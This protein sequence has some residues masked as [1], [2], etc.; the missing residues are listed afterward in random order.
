[1]NN[2]RNLPKVIELTEKLC[3]MI[4]FKVNDQPE[5]TSQLSGLLT[6]SQRTLQVA[7]SVSLQLAPQHVASL[8]ALQGRQKKL[9]NRLMRI[10][11]WHEQ[12]KAI[13]VLGYFLR[14]VGKRKREQLTSQVS[15]IRQTIRVKETASYQKLETLGELLLEL[16][17]GRELKRGWSDHPKL[18][19]RELETICYQLYQEWH[20][21]KRLSYLDRTEHRSW[22]YSLVKEERRLR[23]AGWQGAGI[24]RYIR[25]LYQEGQCLENHQSFLKLQQH[26]RQES[27]LVGSTLYLSMFERTAE[28]TPTQLQKK[29][30]LPIDQLGGFIDEQGMLQLSGSY[31]LS[32][33][34]APDSQFLE[35]Y[36]ETVKRAYP[37]GLLPASY[38]FEPNSPGYQTIK[39]IHQFRMY[40]DR[41]NIYYIRANYSGATDYDKLLA[42][43]KARMTV[44]GEKGQLDY[45]SN[46]HF[47]NRTSRRLPFHGQH[48]DKIKSHNGLSEFIVRRQD[49]A[50]VTQWDS[51]RTVGG[52]SFFIK[53]AGR[54]IGLRSQL[55]N[56]DPEAYELQG[57]SGKRIV[58]T[59]S[60]NYSARDVAK[61]GD[62]SHSLLDVK[63]ANA[64]LGLEHGI[65]IV[66]KKTWR[67]QRATSDGQG[68][69]SP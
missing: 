48:N 23:V 16:C 34:L 2:Q 54:V 30:Q 56:S 37:Q 53:E 69:E 8:K 47:H 15:Q 43:E 63:P 22:I 45:R 62:Q 12:L 35:R 50:F 32:T 26:F 41:Q 60:F 40:L 55:V 42:F 36:A 21:L 1:M 29:A 13:P 38:G 11:R 5:M 61:Q 4:T 28:G 52:Q 20:G 49:G 9:T 66:A 17:E 39:Q 27:C 46:A 33:H 18:S 51:L 65:K 67:T 14:D 3:H 6:Q 10:S 25:V 59:E 7:Q 58:D 19:F 44:L 57:L 31:Q 64:R 24:E 68:M